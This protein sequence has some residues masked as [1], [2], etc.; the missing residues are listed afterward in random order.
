MQVGLEE[1]LVREQ[2]GQA[3]GCSVFLLGS[4]AGSGISTLAAVGSG[5]VVLT[6]AGSENVL[7]TGADGEVCEG[8]GSTSRSSCSLSVS[9]STW[10]ACGISFS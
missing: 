9:E 10:S 1:S 3:P 6:E 7:V 2:I 5:A 4:A 8:D